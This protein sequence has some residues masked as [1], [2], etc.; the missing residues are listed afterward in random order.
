MATLAS[1]QQTKGFSLRD[2]IAAIL[3]L[4]LLP[5]SAIATDAALLRCRAISDA[6]T[7]LACYDA[8]TPAE[9]TTAT[10]AN[11]FGLPTARPAETVQAVDSHIHGRFTGWS[12]RTR[13]NL[14]NGQVWEVTDGSTGV[15]DL[16]NPRVHVRRGALGSFYLEIEGQNRS[17]NVRRVQ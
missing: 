3:P 4:L 13:F 16:M 8:M 10:Q 9:P 7:R 6:A 2:I 15:Y 12:A 14:A 11:R 17:P 5:A 1:S